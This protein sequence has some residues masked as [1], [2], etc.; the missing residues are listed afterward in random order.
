MVRRLARNAGSARAP[1]VT[2]DTAYDV[3]ETALC[4]RW[5][6]ITN[7][8]TTYEGL[9]QCLRFVNAHINRTVSVDRKFSSALIDSYFILTK[10]L[11]LDNYDS[12][13]RCK[14]DHEFR[15]GNHP[16]RSHG[17]LHRF[18]RVLCDPNE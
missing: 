4:H 9:L 18:Q 8:C 7:K 10:Q 13:N 15:E 17:P 6:K 3:G 14:P 2:Y 16:L 12:H 11:V 1:S 5:R